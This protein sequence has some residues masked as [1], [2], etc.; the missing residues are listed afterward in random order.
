MTKR[1]K[2]GETHLGETVIFLVLYA[3]SMVQSRGGGEG[4]EW[5]EGVC[6]HKHCKGEPVHTPL[7]VVD[8]F[9]TW[10]ETVVLARRG[11]SLSEERKQALQHPTYIPKLAQQ[12]KQK[13]CFFKESR[14]T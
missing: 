7:Q 13:C 2:E 12:G 14:T 6:A 11:E 8:V 3:S 10:A 5:G 9:Q 4:G 1:L